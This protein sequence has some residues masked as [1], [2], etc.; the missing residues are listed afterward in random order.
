MIYKETSR[1]TITSQYQQGKET[2]ECSQNAK[3]KQLRILGYSRKTLKKA[4]FRYTPKWKDLITDGPTLRGCL[5]DGLIP[6]A[7]STIHKQNGGQIKW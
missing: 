2:V 5:Q 3:R 6:E 4:H 1:L 7:R